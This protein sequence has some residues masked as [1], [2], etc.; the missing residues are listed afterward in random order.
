MTTNKALQTKLSRITIMY[1]IICFLTSLWMIMLLC[2]NL[3]NFPLCSQSS[4]LIYRILMTPI[5][6]ESRR[7]IFLKDNGVTISRWGKKYSF[8]LMK[9]TPQ[10]KSSNLISICSGLPA[11]LIPLIKQ[12]LTIKRKLQDITITWCTFKM[13]I[14]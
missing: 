3:L 12:I 9:S 2:I 10:S 13:E 4:E 14:S 5:E 7:W 1:P 8:R 11:S 6:T